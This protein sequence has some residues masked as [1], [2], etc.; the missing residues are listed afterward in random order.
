MV[1]TL[2]E[3][4]ARDEDPRLR[5]LVPDVLRYLE[6]N[7]DE[8]LVM[9][10]V[11]LLGTMLVAEA[12]PSVIESIALAFVDLRNP[13]VVTTLRPLATHADAGV[14][15]AVV[16]GLLQRAD[17]AIPE[18][19]ALSRDA[20]DEVRNWATFGL[21]SQTE[22]DTPELRDALVER[23]DDPHDETRAEAALGLACRKDARAIP[24]IVRELANDSPWTHYEEAAALLGVNAK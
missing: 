2:I 19:I 10:S 8:R 24:V 12:T 15:K 23:L 21:G 14:R 6:E 20:N 3:P 18:L 16:H 11:G 13:S 1:W 7:R 5:A 9:R 22:V 17:D 4:F